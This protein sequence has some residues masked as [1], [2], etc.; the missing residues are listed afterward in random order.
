MRAFNR[1]LAPFIFAIAY[2]LFRSSIKQ[3][4]KKK[5]DFVMKL[6]RFAADNGHKRALSVYGH[7]L[8]FRGDGVQ[9]R[10]QGGIYIQQAAEKGDSKA[11]Y[12][13]G[14]IFEEGFEHYFQPDPTKAL[15]FYTQAAEQ[16][17]QLAVRRLVDI[18]TDGELDQEPNQER[19]KQWQAKQSKL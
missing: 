10:I 19:A 13:M 12:Q 9:N 16:T 7:L 15:K 2:A 4:S 8:H 1:L 3:R 14:K 18:Y 5:H 17:H 6:F 11:Q